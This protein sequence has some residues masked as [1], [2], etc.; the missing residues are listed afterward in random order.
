MDN[1]WYTCGAMHRTVNPLAMATL[2]DWNSI[3]RL[4]GRKSLDRIT[5]LLSITSIKVCLTQTFSF[6]QHISWLDHAPIDNSTA[7]WVLTSC[8]MY[9]YF[10]FRHV[11]WVLC[12]AP[13][14][15]NFPFL[16]SSFFKIWSYTLRFLKLYLMPFKNLGIGSPVFEIFSPSLTFLK[17]WLY[18][19]EFLNLLS[20]LLSSFLF[21][22][23]LCVLFISF[24]F[25][26]WSSVLASSSW[27]TYLGQINDILQPNRADNTTYSRTILE[28]LHHSLT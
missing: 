5:A 25:F 12:F 10:F 16:P 6:G 2:S 8:Y 28:F 17:F 26:F 22:L 27:M 13:W 19:F 3:G 18:A 20:M 23:L 4:N 15:L 21:L 7:A 11:K 14:S 24:F 9:V 1:T